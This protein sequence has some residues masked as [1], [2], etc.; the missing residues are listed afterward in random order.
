MPRA[1]RSPVEEGMGIRG[2]DSAERSL[3]YSTE[4]Y[5]ASLPAISRRVSTTPAFQRG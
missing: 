1:G 2:D 4:L 5:P 3:S